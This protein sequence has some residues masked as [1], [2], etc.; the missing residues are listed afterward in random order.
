[1]N[2]MGSMKGC[3]TTFFSSCLQMLTWNESLL[4][5]QM[6]FGNWECSISMSLRLVA[7]LFFVLKRTCSTDPFRNGFSEDVAKLLAAFDEN[8]IS[9]P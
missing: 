6:T 4:L 9:V 7:S 5:T 2:G 3:P 1:M 8:K